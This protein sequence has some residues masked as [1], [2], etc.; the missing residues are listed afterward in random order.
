ME[1]YY[2]GDE[3][4]P[5]D[6][7]F[8]DSG[9]E[10]PTSQTT[11]TTAVTG[12]S[13]LSGES[14]SVLA[15]ASV[16]PNQTVNSSGEVTLQTAATKYR[17]GLGYNSNLQTLPM[18]QPTSAGTSVGN[19]KRIH[20]FVIKLLDS[21]GFKYGS[22]PYLLDTA[23]ISYLESIGV[24]FGAN[25]SNL[26]EAVFRTTADRIGA[27]LLFFTGEKSYTLRDDYGTEAQLYIRQDQPY[28]TNI[29]LLAIDYETNE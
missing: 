5:T 7:H 29:L 10:E 15:D 2:V 21:L 17:I 13:H 14:V 1:R 4:D 22:T 11:A 19:K 25:T 26:T 20:K 28:P 9:L 18:V 23:T 6:A 27:A 3:I 8:V 12:L 16:Q 24:I